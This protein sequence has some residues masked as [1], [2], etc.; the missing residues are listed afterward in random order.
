LNTTP[1]LKESNLKYNAR[2]VPHF[3]NISDTISLDDTSKKAVRVQVM[4][5]YHHRRKQGK[6]SKRQAALAPQE[7]P[8]AKSQTQKFRLGREKVLRPWVPV[9]PYVGKK[10]QKASQKSVVLQKT[11]DISE[12]NEL[13]LREKV[14]EP[15]PATIQRFEVTREGNLNHRDDDT[16]AVTSSSLE[17]PIPAVQQWLSTLQSSLET[18]SFYQS[19]ATGVLDPFSAMSLAITPRTQLLLH[20][21]C[22]QFI[23]FLF[24]ILTDHNSQR[25]PRLILAHDAYEKGSLF[26]RNPRRSS[27]PHFHV[28]LC[29]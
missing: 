2:L 18:F 22:K 24:K 14:K 27:L 17:A 8:T 26:T 12:F 29:R 19:P 7:P 1:P 25:A 28:T 9:K 23:H 21:Y 20:H 6:T 11:V 15:S 13:D 4:R 3:I 16:E 10:S 5:E